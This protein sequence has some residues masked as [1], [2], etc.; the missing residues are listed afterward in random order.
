MNWIDF[1]I[2]FISCLGMLV[3]LIFCVNRKSMVDPFVIS[4][5][6]ELQDIIGRLFRHGSNGDILY[7]L[8]RVSGFAIRIIKIERKTKAD[9]LKAEFRASDKNAN[10][11]L[12]ARDVLTNE[13]IDF[14]EKFTPKLKR[15]SRI[16]L[17]YGD[18]GVFTVSAIAQAVGKIMSTIS[19]S[20]GLDVLASEKEPFFWRKTKIRTMTYGSS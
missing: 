14:D 17:K 8:D 11:Y 6:T 10:G 3:F 12:I 7:I 1:I 20:K 16:Y 5:I 18:G 2:G 13:G 15:P 4:E 19:K 9:T